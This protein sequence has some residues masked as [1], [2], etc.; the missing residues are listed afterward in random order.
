MPDKC[1][2]PETKEER[3]ILRRAIFEGGLGYGKICIPNMLDDLIL[4]IVY[5]P[6]Y[7]ILLEKRN[8][9]KNIGKIILSFILTSLFYFPGLL[10]AIYEKYDM[11]CGGVLRDVI[12][13][14]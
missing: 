5:P 3:I 2:R 9:F 7:I 14:D 10:H 6:A 8:K 11:G 1:A 4:M 12:K 13:D